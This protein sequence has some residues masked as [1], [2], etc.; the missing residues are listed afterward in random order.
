MTERTN[1]IEMDQERLT[2]EMAFRDSS[3]AVIRIQRH[4]PDLLTS[5]KLKYVKLGLHNSCNFTTFLFF[6]IILPLT[7]TVLVQLTGL[8][9]DTFSELWSNRGSNSTG[10]QDSPAPFSSAS[11]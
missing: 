6:L 10:R 5:V 7:G 1:N 8:T 4:L 3:S 9:L 11:L 2:A